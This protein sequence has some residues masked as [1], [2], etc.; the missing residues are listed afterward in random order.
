MVKSLFSALL[1]LYICKVE[2]ALDM[3]LH[4]GRVV[5]NFGM[6]PKLFSVYKVPVRYPTCYLIDL[7]T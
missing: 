2:V 7:P 1:N 5:L 6:P 3:F 4:P